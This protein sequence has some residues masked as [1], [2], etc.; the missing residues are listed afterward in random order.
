MLLRF[1]EAKV[2]DYAPMRRGLKRISPHPFRSMR[3]EC[4]QRLCPDEKGIETHNIAVVYSMRS[5]VRDYAPMRR[6]LKQSQVLTLRSLKETSQRLCPDE[7]GIE[8]EDHGAGG[9]VVFGFVRDYAPMR[10]GLKLI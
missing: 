2:R 10:R 5:Q 8:T 1:E 3:N 9:S 6:G 7:K 4:G